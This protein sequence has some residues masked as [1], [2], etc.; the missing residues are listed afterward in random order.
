MADYGVRI[1]HPDG[2]HFDF[3]ERSTLCR[4]LGSGTFKGK[5]LG[6]VSTDHVEYYNTGIHVP[7]GYDWWLW[8]T[9]NAHMQTGA[10]IG[11]PL[12]NAPW[13]ISLSTPFLDEKRV[14]N[15][16]WDLSDADPEMHRINGIGVATWFNLPDV[17]YGAIAWPVARNRNYGFSISGADNMA[18]VFDTS[19]VS[20]L[21]W[22]GE[23]DIYNG[24]TPGNINP[25]LNMNNC[26]CFFYTTSPEIVIGLDSEAKYRIWN[27]GRLSTDPV[28][29]KVCIFGNGD[30]I[31]SLA[32]YGM[33]IWNPDTGQLVYNSGRDVL[34]RP[35]LVSMSG[36]AT[37][38][39]TKFNCHGVRAAGIR[40]PM[41]A[42]TNTG[43]AL[44]GGIAFTDDGLSMPIFYTWVSSDGY[45]LY[46]Y[47][48]GQTAAHD[49]WLSHKETFASNGSSFNSSTNSVMVIDAEDYFV[50]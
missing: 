30:L 40:R 22:K 9:L 16:R 1:Y 38:V 23:V 36:S 17:V 4:V 15:V 25:A 3:N 37:V 45:S 5:F 34:L 21:Q 10:I 2:S 49:Y 24:W 46:Q 7:E 26:L 14:I 47:P 35:Q 13:G 48:G 29:V 42:P 43:V 39:D 28:R 50:F 31:P 41:Y 11:Y 8:M 12:S 18:G 6:S 20:Y 27:K 19:L 33:E 32:E 44:L